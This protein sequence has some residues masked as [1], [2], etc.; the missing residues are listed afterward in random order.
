MIDY[1]ITLNTYDNFFYILANNGC[2]IHRPS[3]NSLFCFL[4]P[5]FNPKIVHPQ[6]QKRRLMHSRKFRKVHQ[7]F[8][9]SEDETNKQEQYYAAIDD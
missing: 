2:Q 1:S 3:E 4:L 9:E 6:G 7:P 5:T 8:F